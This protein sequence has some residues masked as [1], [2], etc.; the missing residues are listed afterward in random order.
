MAGCRAACWPRKS[1]SLQSRRQGAGGVR[2]GAHAVFRPCWDRPTAARRPAPPAPTTME[3]KVWSTIG[4][5]L[6]LKK[7]PLSALLSSRPSADAAF[8]RAVWAGGGPSLADRPADRWSACREGC[9][10]APPAPWGCP[11]PRAPRCA[12][13]CHNAAC[14]VPSGGCMVRGGARRAAICPPAEHRGAP[15]GNPCPTV[16]PGCYFGV[17]RRVLAQHCLNRWARRAPSES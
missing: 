6:L 12:S 13:S 1:A 8:L 5:A 3:S 17:G 9:N 16:S 15:L 2:R 14:R 10:P 11:G 7:R 4:Y